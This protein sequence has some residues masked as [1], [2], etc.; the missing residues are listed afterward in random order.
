MGMSEGQ[1]KML[2][3]IFPR[4]VIEF[5]SFTDE[6]QRLETI[7]GLARDH[8]HATI[9]FMDIVGFTSMAKQVEPQVVMTFLNQLFTVFDSMCGVYGAQ[10]VETA[11]DCYIAAAGI[12]NADEEGFSVVHNEA[13]GQPSSFQDPVVGARRVMSLA[14]AMMAGSKT[15]MMPHNGEPVS[16]RI[17]MHT[18]PCVSGLIGTKLPKFSI[19][20]DTMNTASRME[21]TSHP[22]LIQVSKATW[23]LLKD[24]ESFRPT[25]G[26]EIKGKGL[27]PTF[28]WAEGGS[29]RISTANSSQAVPSQP[30][31]QTQFTPLTSP[32]IEKALKQ[33]LWEQDGL[34]DLSVQISSGLLD[35]LDNQTQ[36]LGGYPLI[37]PRV[38]FSHQQKWPMR[39][40]S[41]L[42][43][44]ASLAPPHLQASSQRPIA[45]SVANGPSMGIKGGSPL[46]TPQD[47]SSS[48][49][50]AQALAAAFAAG[51]DDLVLDHK[52]NLFHA[53]RTVSASP[54]QLNDH[55]TGPSPAGS[56]L[57]SQTNRSPMGKLS[58]YDKAVV[59]NPGL[60][61]M[62]QSSLSL[63]SLLQTSREDGAV[64]S[65]MGQASSGWAAAQGLAHAQA[66]Q[67]RKSAF[68]P[69]S[70]TLIDGDI[71][72][73]FQ[74]CL[75]RNE[76]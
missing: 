58:S 2:G 40:S 55:G 9:L 73:S 52:R 7:G 27:M 26:I 18:G 31:T 51:G 57:G 61:A 11:G 17:G 15:V 47:R 69:S 5:M 60:V 46:M 62:C 67:K 56:H 6:K 1:L 74:G 42:A 36:R 34:R 32:D 75:E 8:P 70:E 22:G 13:E 4:H 19:F 53:N 23:E 35:P 68:A 72:Q 54:Q 21:S 43:D 38:S 10:K 45:A 66:E 48:L 29:R 41:S 76:C 25:G 44:I 65:A 30:L 64:S 50:I 39:K 14:K 33:S 3:G 20:G 12:L 59:F 63:Q 24:T 71:L 28:I 37:S 16:I 49:V